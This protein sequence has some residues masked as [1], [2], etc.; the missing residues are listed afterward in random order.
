MAF[1]VA[2]KNPFDLLGDENE[3]LS[4]AAA[5]A[6]AN[7]EAKSKAEAA[8]KKAAETAKPT[9][10][11]PIF[12]DRRS[13]RRPHRAWGS[14]TRRGRA[15]DAFALLSIRHI[16]SRTHSAL[17]PISLGGV[18]TARR[19]RSLAGGVTSQRHT[20]INGPPLLSA[21]RRAVAAFSIPT[22]AA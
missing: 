12:E 1:G 7:A 16:A 5:R 2:T 20:P 10:A 14:L 9:G 18:R 6:A 15:T 17:E 13:R 11:N 19:A 3:D 22:V 4:A 21:S 8:E